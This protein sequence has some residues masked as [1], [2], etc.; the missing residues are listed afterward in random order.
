[1]IN[2]NDLK[3]DRII[4][5]RVHK[6]GDSANCGIAEF[7]NE[8]FNFGATE[9]ET[10]KKRICTA[11]SKTKRFFKLEIARCEADSFYDYAI[12]IKGASNDVFVEKSQKIADLLALSHDRKT[13]PSGL[14]LVLDGFYNRTSHF[15]LVIK[16]E[17]QEAFTIKEADEHKY[18]ELINDLFL[19]P[20]KDFYK[21]GYLIEEANLAVFPNNNHSAYMYDDNF[22]SGNRDLAEYFY[23]NFLG[24]STNKN[25][26]L[27]TKNFYNDVSRFIENNVL[28]FDDKKGLKNALNTLY[29]E[30]ITG[31]INPQ[32]FIE[33]YFDSELQRK[34]N[35]MI[36][37][38][39][40]HSFTKDLSLV[41]KR[42]R[43]GQI[44][45]VDE[46]KIEG[47]TDSLSNVNV[48]NGNNIDFEALRLSVENGELS[49]LITIKTGNVEYVE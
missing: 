37:N 11:F 42:L 8:L 13:I 40:P 2:P 21:I 23:S 33:Q 39:Y 12:Q 32:E 20:A 14:L 49:Q 48:I 47:P 4:I 36:G 17:L 41:D 15:V 28:G 7:S 44:K 45:L 31:V 34:Y 9:T 25:D 46:L 19:S 10:L 27:L 38:N 6:K 18:I 26:K 29:R 5:H 3:I 22:S 43:R 30:N 24:F 1:M 16:A 35:R